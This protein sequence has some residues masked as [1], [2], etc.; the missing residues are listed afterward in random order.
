MNNNSLSLRGEE[1]ASNPARVDME[2]FFEASQNLYCPETNPDGAFLLNVAE[3]HL[4]SGYIKKELTDIT[5]NS[6]IPDW[7]LNYT[8]PSG[9]PE[10]RETIALFMEKHLCKCPIHPDTIG[11]SAGAAAIIEISSF[12]LA[13]KGEVVVIPSPSYPVYTGD[14]GIKSGLERYDLQTHFHIE[15]T[16]SAAPV[17]IPILEKAKTDLVAK[18]KQ[19][20]ILLITS[21]DNPTGC[22]YGEGQLRELANWCIKNEVHM[23]VNEIY[24]FSQIDTSDD[25]ISIDYKED[26]KY[27]SFANVMKDLHSDY[28]HL[29]YGL[30]KDFAMSGLRFG[31]VHS[32][33]QDF[34]NAFRNGNIPH[35]VSNHTQW[36]IGELFKRNDFLEDYIQEN[37]KQVTTSYKEVVKTLKKI[38]V[39][40]VPARGS[41][42]IWTDLSKYL[43]EDTDQGQEDLWISIYK[44]TGVLLTPG[45][46]FG[47]QKKGLFR[48]VHSALP[49]SHLKVAMEKLERYLLAQ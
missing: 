15:E 17:T 18:G 34:M 42:F 37:K 35:M 48:I 21:P 36:M 24:A 9:H 7:V 25:L 30:S 38:G 32:L 45:A 1:L 20:K 12:I 33:N 11:F 16:G 23:V 26:V 27:S 46:G 6:S 28:L 39:P 4:M 8:D 14:I 40:Y 47:H 22:M 3:N 43:K 31:I 44:N 10:V 2:L 49:T 19:F 41:L 5:L 13:D 29:W